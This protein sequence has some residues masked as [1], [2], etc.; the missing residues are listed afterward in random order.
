MNILTLSSNLH[1]IL[2][3]SLLHGIQCSNQHLHFSYQGRV[4]NYYYYGLS[5]VIVQY[6]EDKGEIH[7]GMSAVRLD[8]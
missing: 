6:R 5:Q 2:Y 7:M 4:Y 8:E 1:Y 3:Q